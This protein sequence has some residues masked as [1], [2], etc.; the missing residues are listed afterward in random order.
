MNASSQWLRAVYL[1]KK[2]PVTG[3]RASQL[4]PGV[5]KIA[6]VAQ[7]SACLCVISAHVSLKHVGLHAL[8]V[9]SQCQS[10]LNPPTNNFSRPLSALANP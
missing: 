5:K 7:H 4:C 8:A 6:Y 3:S 2:N 10:R 9:H 1:K